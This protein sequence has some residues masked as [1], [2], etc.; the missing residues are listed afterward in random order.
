[1]IAEITPTDMRCAIAT[2][3]PALY[4]VTPAEMACLLSQCP[5]L[6][7]TPPMPGFEGGGV[8][9]IGKVHDVTALVADRIGPDEF[10]VLVPKKLLKNIQWSEGQ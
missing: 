7:E 3:C 4:D 10:A 9:V 1:M 2:S 5:S 6:I 8:I